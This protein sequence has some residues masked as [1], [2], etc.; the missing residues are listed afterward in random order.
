MSITFELNDTPYVS[1]LVEEPDGEPW[2]TQ[3][4]APGWISI[5]MSNT[6]ATD[7]L[8]LLD[9]ANDAKKGYGTWDLETIHDILRRLVKLRNMQSKSFEKPTKI[10]G[11]FVDIGRDSEYVD[12]KLNQMNVLLRS[13][14][15]K[16]TV[17]TFS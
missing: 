17:V 3:V 13:A 15:E 16:Q 10:S 14:L 4:P 11:D 8:M 2:E 6:N 12:R 5:N 7:L 1:E 9:R